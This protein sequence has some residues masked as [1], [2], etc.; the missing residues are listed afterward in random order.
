MSREGL[1]ATVLPMISGGGCAQYPVQHGRAAE[2]LH[3]PG[4][5]S[6]QFE[7]SS[8]SPRNRAYHIIQ[9]MRGLKPQDILEKQA[10]VVEN[11]DAFQK[12]S[13]ELAEKEEALENATARQ[14]ELMAQMNLVSSELQ[15]QVLQLSRDLELSKA[16]NERLQQHASR[17]REIEDL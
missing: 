9:K 16:S 4:S 15:A 8:I 12:A 5:P 2:P 17:P 11:A 10:L 14:Q 13:E 1:L 7:N 6:S 3:G